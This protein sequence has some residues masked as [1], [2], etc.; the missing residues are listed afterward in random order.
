MDGEMKGGLCICFGKC[1]HGVSDTRM[2][3]F[4][5]VKCKLIAKF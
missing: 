1:S 4:D 2:R 5:L 3:E